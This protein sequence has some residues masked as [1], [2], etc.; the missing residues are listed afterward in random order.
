MFG[1]KFKEE[2]FSRKT[3]I[4]KRPK[5]AIHLWRRGGAEVKLA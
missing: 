4:T 5:L 1:R 2:D 3:Q